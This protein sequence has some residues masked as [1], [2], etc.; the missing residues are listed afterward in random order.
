V[1]GIEFGK[2]SVSLRKK[3]FERNLEIVMNISCHNGIWL[4][5]RNR[6]SVGL[7]VAG[8]AASSVV[9]TANATLQDL[10]A[11]LQQASAV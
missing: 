8:G 6:R 3:I 4:N 9:T 1:I 10:L 7:V 5:G 2:I 11:A